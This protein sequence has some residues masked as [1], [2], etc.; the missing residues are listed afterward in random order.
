V[1]VG[2]GTAGSSVTARFTE[3]PIIDYL[4]LEA[5]G[6]GLDISQKN[7]PPDVSKFCFTAKQQYQQGLI[8]ISPYL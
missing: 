2:G 7:F 8:I 1:T 3:E 6:N 4:V 5:G